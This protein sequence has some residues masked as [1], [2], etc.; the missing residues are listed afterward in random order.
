MSNTKSR[1]WWLLGPVTVSMVTDEIVSENGVPHSHIVSRGAPL[2]KRT[3][4]KP[5]AKARG[6]DGIISLSEQ[7]YSLQVSC[8]EENW[9][10]HCTPINP[11]SR[12]T[13]VQNF[14]ENATG[15]C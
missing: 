10:F 6:T 8:S 15:H 4:K 5:V 9:A 11:H 1:F 14:I 12:I 13:R 7:S 2:D 3:G